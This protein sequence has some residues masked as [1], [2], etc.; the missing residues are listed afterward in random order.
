[1]VETVEIECPVVDICHS[2][3]A[4][5]TGADTKGSSTGFRET[6]AAGS[7]AL[8]D[9]SGDKDITA[10]AEGQETAGDG[11]GVSVDRGDLQG[12]RRVVDEGLGLIGGVVVKRETVSVV[13]GDG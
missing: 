6:V 4:R 13:T 9:I 2:F 11:A 5:D 12:S 7:R 8:D 1:M 10:A 3:E